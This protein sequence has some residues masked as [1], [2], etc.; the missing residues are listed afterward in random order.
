MIMFAPTILEFS[1]EKKLL[2]TF[3]SN[4]TFLIPKSKLSTTKIILAS[5]NGTIPILQKKKKR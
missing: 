3:A 5:F 2:N 4:A 1:D